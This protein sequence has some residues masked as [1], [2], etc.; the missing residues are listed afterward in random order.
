MICPQFFVFGAS[1]LNVNAKQFNVRYCSAT[2]EYERFVRKSNDQIELEDVAKKWQSC[3]Y[4]WQNV[5]R[6]E[7][8]DWKMVYLARAEDTDHAEIE[9]K[10]DFSDRK[11]VI[12]DIKL[13]FDYKIYESGEIEVFFLHKGEYCDAFVLTSFCTIKIYA[14]P[15]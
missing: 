2:N 10:F 11:L 9:W 15:F 12:K 3:A 6:K 8:H 1:E 4:R 13:K 5:L 7:E 14:S